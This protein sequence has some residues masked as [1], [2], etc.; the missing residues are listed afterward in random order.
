MPG[1]G[2]ATASIA[3]TAENITVT[4]S[5]TKR[6]TSIILTKTVMINIATNRLTQR[7]YQ[8]QVA[9]KEEDKN[10]RKAHGG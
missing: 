8:K 5:T 3:I 4:L 6:E 9:K 10:R 1:V 2:L 7:C